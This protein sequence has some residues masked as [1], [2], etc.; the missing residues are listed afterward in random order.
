MNLS[1]YSVKRPITVL[2]AVLMVLLLGA[3]SITR[4]NLELMPDMNLPYSAVI[5]TY[6]GANPYEV[7]EEVTK[8]IESAMQGVSNFKNI[9]STS[10]EN[11]SIVIV[12]F[13]QSTNMDTAFLDMRERLDTLEFVEGVGN[14]SIMKFDPSMMPIMVVS[15]TRD[16]GSA[17]D[18]ELILTSEWV[19]SDLITR[20]EGIE[21]V[22]SV[23]INGASD[24]VLELDLNEEMLAEVGLTEQEVLDTVE[25]QNIEG[26]IGVVPDGEVIRFL[27]LGNG[28]EGMTQLE[29]TP[30][31]YTNKVVYLKDL[32]NEIKFVNQA[33]NSYNK[34]NGRDAVTVVFY[35]Q[36]DSEITEVV[37]N[38]TEKLD[39]EVTN[40][41]FDAEYQVIMNQGE[42][43]Q[44]AVGSV[45]NNLII[46]AIAAVVVLFLFLR[47]LRPT[48][49]VG[50]AIPTSVVGALLLMFF[51]GLSLNVISMGGLALGIGMLVDNSIVVIENIFRLLKK[52]YSKKEAAIQGAKQVAM[53]ITASTL[54]T[55]VVFVPVFFI[56]NLIVDVFRS[57][58]LTVTYSLL[59][60]LVIALTLVPSISSRI[61]KEQEEEEK[62]GRVYVW[63]VSS[64]RFILK[65]KLVTMIAVLIV[66]GL[67][68]WGGM[69]KG[70][71]MMPSSDEGQISI[72]IEMEKGTTFEKTTE[73]TDYVVEIVDTFNEV[74]LV[75]AEVGGSM[76]MF[77]GGGSTDSSSITVLLKDD[78]NKTSFEV[79]D[80]IQDVLDMINYDN[81]EGV[82]DEDVISISSNASQSAM[83]A[84]GGAMFSTGVSVEVIGEDLY[85]M[86]IVANDLVGLLES[87][88][89]LK[90][91]S[92]GI[93]R[94]DDVVRIEVDKEVAIKYGL[95]EKDVQT[96]IE[97]FYSS[98]GFSLMDDTNT[99]LIIPIDGVSYDIT[100]P[101]QEF[102]MSQVNALD[103]LG[104]IKVFDAET[105]K[106]VESAIE[107]GQ[108]IYMPNI[109]F[110]DAEETIPNPNFD[111]NVA[112]GAL[113]INPSLR[114]VDGEIYAIT[115]ADI[116][117]GNDTD[118]KLS[119]VATKSV[120]D[121]SAE[122]ITIIDPAATGFASIS[123][124]GN[125]R[126]LTV[127]AALENGYNQSQ[128]TEEIEKLIETY[129]ETH[130][131]DNLSI[132][133]QDDLMNTMQDLGLAVVIAV[134]L[135]YMI[136][137]IQFQ[138]LVYPLIVLV[139]VPL[140]FTG[141][142]LALLV[143][144]MPISLPAMVGFMMLTGIIVNNGIVL[145][146]YINQQR[147]KGMD[148]DL[149]L[150]SAGVTRLRPIFMTAATTSIA[151]LPMA[152]GFGEG[153]E[154]LQ[155]LA[156]TSIGGLLYGTVL[157]LYVVPVMYKVFTRESKEA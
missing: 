100:L 13:S 113:V 130:Q 73:F 39:E 3:F 146:D 29:E 28:I 97:L 62:K 88:E 32:V 23:D 96:A 75:S 11:F 45:T 61:L 98:L 143:L 126:L 86:E 74:D 51:T 76:M 36:S 132:E 85:D 46:G 101:A 109:E 118:E 79:A 150:Y 103:F 136:M 151:L 82:N 141:A 44:Q 14:P 40:S 115:F 155:P 108:M 66:L 144:D 34:V 49:V 60:S 148:V 117:A 68:I 147:A 107:E 92:N 43:I 18:Q 72:S 153:A 137:A 127:S 42:Y 99:N 69:A 135:V 21:G 55:V 91:L 52:G 116:M 84:G 4:L 48:I 149:S 112:V 134:L 90:D 77:S 139:T 10:N 33:T 123:R 140:A 70:F 95:T 53:A 20:F 64:L 105:G 114:I 47:N 80:D 57:M 7:E 111:P 24:T 54:T 65:N 26:L 22:A 31:T 25:S 63:Y 104:Y 145:I 131:F 142:F 50:L 16:F 119:D 94:S 8:P 128:V 106:T 41:G 87:V 152:L 129:E 5:T 19:E 38:I 138:S 6:P 56:D 9:S 30:I 133:I 59:A 1:E 122:P 125:A 157:T 154:L 15:I 93:Q 102:D 156:I 67:S 27:Y 110:F 2:M 83:S 121:S 35:Q 81:V 78:R 17:E 12:E 89:G 120:Y 124:N 37:N 71:E 58:A